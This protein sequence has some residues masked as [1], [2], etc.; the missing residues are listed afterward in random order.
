[1]GALRCGWPG[2]CNAA[3]LEGRSRVR[4]CVWVGAERIPTIP[5]WVDLNNSCVWVQSGFHNPSTRLHPTLAGRH[6][7]LQ[8]RG[9]HAADGR[10]KLHQGGRR[11]CAPVP[12]R[13][14]GAAARKGG[15]S[16]ICTKVDGA[17]VR[18]FLGAS[19][20]L[21]LEA[22]QWPLGHR[23]SHCNV[24][25]PSARLSRCGGSQRR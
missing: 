12:G 25:M 2:A 19:V 13:P 22:S 5:Q 20:V 23:C 14:S 10:P 15:P 9:G 17:L 4:S 21:Q 3:S 7:G 6:R 8:Q 24:D 1:M 11:A 16:Q 18:L